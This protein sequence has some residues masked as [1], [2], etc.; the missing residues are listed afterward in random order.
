MAGPV[1][2]QSAPLSAPSPPFHYLGVGEWTPPNNLIPAGTIYVGV[3]G[4]VIRSQHPDTEF[5]A[6]APGAYLMN[7]AIWDKFGKDT[8]LA[9]KPTGSEQNGPRPVGL[10]INSSN[11]VAIATHWA[12]QAMHI[13]GGQPGVDAPIAN[14]VNVGGVANGSQFI[15]AHEQ[16]FGL[17][18]WA[19]EQSKGAVI[20]HFNQADGLW[21]QAEPGASTPFGSIRLTPK[22][23]VRSVYIHPSVDTWTDMQF[24]SGHKTGG[25]FLGMYHAGSSFWGAGLHMNFGNGGGEFLGSFLDFRTNGA[26]VFRITPNGDLRHGRLA[27]RIA[28]LEAA[29][30]Q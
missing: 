26:T 29:V 2:A 6:L 27:E 30:G 20:Q 16:S 1:S 11:Q 18:V 10:L 22:A 13:I 15:Q 24:V 9:M 5:L 21:I 14:L 4:T 23:N 7:V 19:L 28:A 25:Q 3:P 8:P 12:H 17:H